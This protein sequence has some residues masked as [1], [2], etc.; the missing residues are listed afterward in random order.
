M[1]GTSDIYDDPEYLSAKR[2]DYAD[3]PEG[4]TPVDPI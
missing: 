2:G 1:A 4:W 3:H